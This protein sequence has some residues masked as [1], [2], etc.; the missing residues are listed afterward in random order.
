MENKDI[1]FN[2]VQIQENER[3]RI[4]GEIH[5][6]SLQ[7]LVHISHQVEL[8]SLHIDND[9]VKAKDLMGEIRKGLKDLIDETRNVI[10]NLRPMSFDDL[11]FTDATA[12]YIKKLND[13]SSINYTYDFEDVSQEIPVVR[14]SLYRCVQECLK[15]CEKH[16]QA[17]NVHVSIFKKNDRLHIVIIDDGKGFDVDSIPGTEQNHFGL[18]LIKERIDAFGGEVIISSSPGKGTKITLITNFLK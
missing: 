7:S 16:S 15:N 4:A 1:I 13:Q 6:T 12:S 5:D 14:L 8:A 9:P 3:K 2:I 18:S 17:K 10:F 11:S